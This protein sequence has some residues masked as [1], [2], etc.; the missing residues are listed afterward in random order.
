MSN[1]DKPA[2]P[3]TT[4]NP[5]DHESAQGFIGLT[6]RELIAA[7]AMQGMLSHD[8]VHIRT[9]SKIASDAVVMADYLLNE[10]EEKIIK[11]K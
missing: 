4:R 1:S 6:K 8:A 9:M 11:N 7:M 5:W 2:M 3:F 10:L